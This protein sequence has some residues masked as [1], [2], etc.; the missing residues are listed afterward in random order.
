VTGRLSPMGR[1]GVAVSVAAAAALAVGTWQP[2]GA[3]PGQSPGAGP[4]P[5]PVA[6]GG[7]LGNGRPAVSHDGLMVRRCTAVAVYPAVPGGGGPVRRAL[8]AAASRA[9]LTLVDLP[10][11]VLSPRTLRRQ[12]PEVVDCLPPAATPGDATRL[13]SRPLAGAG[14]HLVETVLVH[15]LAFTVRPAGRSPAAVTAALD[16]EGILADSLG[17]YRVRTVGPELRI[18]YTGLLLGDDEVGT[19]RAA[20]ARP[21]GTDPAAV[22]VGPRSTAGTGVRLADEPSPADPG[23]EATHHH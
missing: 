14:R 17:R 11:D 20:I 21:A 2:P 10:P 13:L 5:R 1:L 23:P 22:A 12:V 18:L 9:G 6:A 7:E 19:V 16:R 3:G 15:D 4:Q 8:R